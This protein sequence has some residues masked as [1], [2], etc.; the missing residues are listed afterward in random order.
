MIAYGGDDCQPD[1]LAHASTTDGQPERAPS[2]RDR[3]GRGDGDHSTD[4]DPTA[5]T[6]ADG[7]AF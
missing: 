7:G 6:C 1:E 4:A 2:Y 3:S 5:D